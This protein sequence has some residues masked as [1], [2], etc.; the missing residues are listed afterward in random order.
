MERCKYC[1]NADAQHSE[2]YNGFVCVDCYNEM[3]EYEE[4]ESLA[5]FAD[6]DPFAN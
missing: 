6:H 3:S 4:M 2:H 1:E 5:A